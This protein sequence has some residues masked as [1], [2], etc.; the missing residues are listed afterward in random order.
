[1]RRVDLESSEWHGLLGRS[2]ATPFHHPAWISVL[3]DTYGF[4]S[5]GL[6]GEGETEGLPVIEVALPPRGKRRWVSLPFTDYC[7][8]LSASVGVDSDLAHRLDVARMEADIAQLEVRAPLEGGEHTPPNL[9]AIR[10]VL[11]LGAGEEELF[12]A[13]H[14]SHRRSVNRA[15]R[16]GITVR[17]AET[18]SDLVDVFYR[19]HLMNRRRLG[20]PI[21][22]RRYFRLLWRRMLEPGLGQLF[23]AY[24]GTQPVA[25]VVVLRFKRTA[26]YKYSALNPRARRLRPNHLVVWRAIQWSIEG[27]AEVFDFGRTDVGHEGLRRFKTG[28]GAQEEELAY[29]TLGDSPSAHGRQTPRLLGAAI[30]HSPPFV[31]RVIGEL[32]YKYAA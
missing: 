32:S 12:R 2:D 24:S 8:P 3:S 14:G 19:L 4:R 25:G 26:I 13:V 22:P 5:F 30:R 27:G 15:L 18:E 17:P 7:P 6:V 20:V 16:E 11:P 23:L 9:R 1:M 10:T 29:A 31:C 21:Q 28:W